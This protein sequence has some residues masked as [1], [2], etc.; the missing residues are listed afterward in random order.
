MFK[1]IMVALLFCG[2]GLTS[3]A[4]FGDNCESLTS[5]AGSEARI[6]DAETGIE[7]NA[8]GQKVESD[9]QTFAPTCVP[10]TVG[11]D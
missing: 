11:T 8:L 10:D 6:I 9:K 7:Y 3:P 2:C 5:V 1:V 4:D